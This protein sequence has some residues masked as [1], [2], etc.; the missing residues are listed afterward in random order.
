LIS[1]RS[2]RAVLDSITGPIDCDFFVV[3]VDDSLGL[4]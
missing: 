1:I 3:I 2:S 4:L